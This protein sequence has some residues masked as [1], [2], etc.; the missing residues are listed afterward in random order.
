MKPIEKLAEELS[1]S[2]KAAVDKYVHDVI[3]QIV[4]GISQ[5]SSS[6]EPGPVMT[7]KPSV[8]S[9]Q[10]P[11]N[12]PSKKLDMHCRHPGCKQRSK[13]PR[14]HYL[15]DKHKLPAKPKPVVKA[16]QPA[17]KP[18]QPKKTK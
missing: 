16:K 11:V 6:P 7:T 5:P 1:S 12:L 4:D 3:K 2:V 14:F 9:I 17:P 10:A 18:K 8:A 13:G 15:C